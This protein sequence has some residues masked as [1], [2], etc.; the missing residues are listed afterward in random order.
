[1]Q[2]SFKKEKTVLKYWQGRYLFQA[3]FVILISSIF[4]TTICIYIKYLTLKLIFSSITILTVYHMLKSLKD[5]VQDK[6]ER[7]ILNNKSSH[8]DNLEFDYGKGL[9]DIEIASLNLIDEYQTREIRNTIKSNNFIIEEDWFYNVTSKKSL[10]INDTVFEGIIYSKNWTNTT[11]KTGLL[12][13]KGQKSIITGDIITEL[14]SEEIKKLTQLAKIFKATELKLA[15]K[16]N[17]FYALIKTKNK[18]YYQFGLF[19]SN[20]T[21]FINRI[22][23][24]TKLL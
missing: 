5:A 1:M 8:F 4:I 15:I 23:V 3:F 14:K 11:D 21:Y 12:R 19:N 24:I 18:L 17:K 16:N 20:T 9:P 13:I 10:A 7:V 6:G 2:T 22:N